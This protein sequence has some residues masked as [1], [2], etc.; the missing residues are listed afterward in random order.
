MIKPIVQELDIIRDRS[1]ILWNIEIVADSDHED[2]VELYM[3]DHHG[4]RVE[5]GTFDMAGLMNVILKFYND[6]Y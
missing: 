2:K 4:H 1:M 3:L 5:G 6:N